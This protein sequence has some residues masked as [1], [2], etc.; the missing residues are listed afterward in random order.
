MV[1][2]IAERLR[3]FR[4]TLAIFA[5]ALFLADPCLAQIQQKIHLPGPG[6]KNR[7]GM[8]MDLDC[9]GSESNGYRPIRVKL[10]NLPATANTFDRQVRVTLKMM[11]GQSVYGQLA[12]SQVVEIPEGSTTGEA[13]ISMPSDGQGYYMSLEVREGGQRLEELCSSY[14]PFNARGGWGSGDEAFPSLLFVNSAIPDREKRDKLFAD[15]L[16]QIPETAPTYDIPDIRNLAASTHDRNANRSYGQITDRSLLTLVENYP[17]L[18]LLPPSEL[19]ERWIDLS[20]YGILFI[21]REDL[22]TLATKFPQRKL[23]VQQWLAQGSV[24]VVFDAGEEYEHLAEIEKL[25]ELPALPEAA[26]K[27]V[28]YRDWSPAKESSQPSNKKYGNSPQSNQNYAGVAMPAMPGSPGGTGAAPAVEATPKP[29]KKQSLV[30]PFV[31]RPAHLGWLIAIADKNPFPGQ[32]NEWERLLASIPDQRESWSYRHGMTLRGRN[33][34]FW[35][36]HIAGVGAAP[37]FSFILLATLFAIAIGPL[38]YLFLG[39]IQ[40]LSM[41]LFTVPAGALVVTIALFLYALVT[42]GLGVRSRVRSY[43][44]LDQRSG[45]M[46]SWSRQTYFAS[47]APSRGL[48]YP[49][50]SLV[51]PMLIKQNET[52]STYRAL[53]WEPDGQRLKYGFLASRSLGQFMVV[54][55]AKSETRLEV[56]EQKSAPQLQVRNSLGTKVQF[57]VLRD[58]QGNYFAAENLPVD[59]TAEPASAREDDSREALAKLMKKQE[60]NYPDGYSPTMSGNALHRMFRGA[61]PSGGGFSPVNTSASLLE[62]SLRTITSSKGELLEPGTYLAIVDITPDVPMGV[63]YSKQ[64]NSLQVIRG[65]W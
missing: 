1:Q 8:M 13:V 20:T 12:V 30:P 4:L 21:S 64:K 42:D 51:F 58:S 56:T 50:D 27:G 5:A 29:P 41:L 19:P 6:V 40:R 63:S 62:H 65:R 7:C 28:P 48:K 34:D 61:F 35:N 14:L 47:I 11:Y 43:T 60:P 16:G 46:V 59:A 52:G 26:K 36:W 57:L 18:E 23:A 2:Q 32:V 22:Q 55:S 44:L 17:S 54:R 31:S 25:L 37:V 39:K 49:A 45:Q 10:S 53:D 9:R 38:N 15:N 24:L 33:D 3:R